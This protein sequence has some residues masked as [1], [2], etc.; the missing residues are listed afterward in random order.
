M[1]INFRIKMMR[2]ALNMTQENFAESLG[3]AKRTY[4]AY[5]RGDRPITDRLI[6]SICA[7]HGI[8]EHWLRTGEGKMFPPKNPDDEFAELI[9]D[10]LADEEDSF[11]RRLVT[12][13]CKLDDNQIEAVK[14]F[15]REIVEGEKV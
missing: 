13:I 6:V 10:L 2:K 14:E 1:D 12:A 9:G 3:L 7:V 8:D 15:M 4:I 5:E 11:R